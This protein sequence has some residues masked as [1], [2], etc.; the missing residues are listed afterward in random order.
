MSRKFRGEC[1]ILYFDNPR[2]ANYFDD[3]I[4]DMEERIK[5]IVMYQKALYAF[6]WAVPLLVGISSEMDA[7]WV[8]ALAGDVRAAYGVETLVILLTVVCVPL[9]LK[10]FAWVLVR[11]IDVAGIDRALRL[12]V[13]W[14]SV[15]ALLLF[16][17]AFG[18]FLGYCLLLSNKCLLCGLI[19]LAAMLFC[20][21]GQK[22]L[23]SELHI[24]KEVE[25]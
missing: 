8:G 4:C 7:P 24:D 22:R 20:V 10:L 16:L 3:Y 19:A 12:Y 15:R 11:R 21:P 25:G 9:A 5:R 17:P 1:V 23:R 6:C 18:G 2:F 13:V 14:S